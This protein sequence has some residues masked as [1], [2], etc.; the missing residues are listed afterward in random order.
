[1]TEQ[2]LLKAQQALSATNWGTK[3]ASVP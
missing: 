1:M 3:V 2:K